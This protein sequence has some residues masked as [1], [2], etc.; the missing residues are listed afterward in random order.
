[1]LIADSDNIREVIAFPKKQKSKRP[2]YESASKVT[3]KQLKDVH[4]KVD[5]EENK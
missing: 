1:M 5:V 3:D 4:I 2:T